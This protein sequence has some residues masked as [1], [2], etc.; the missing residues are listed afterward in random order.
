M[1]RP[2]TPRSAHWR[3][4]KDTMKRLEAKID[5][6]NAVGNNDPFICRACLADQK[7]DPSI[8]TYRAPTYEAFMFHLRRHKIGAKMYRTMYNATTPKPGNKNNRYDK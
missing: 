8:P 6:A 4:Y 3:R 2:K 7:N 1:D 5:R